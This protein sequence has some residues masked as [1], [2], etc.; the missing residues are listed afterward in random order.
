M[1]DL[2]IS[3]GVMAFISL[4]AIPRPFSAF[5]VGA[6]ILSIGFGVIGFMPF[7]GVNLE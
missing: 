1:Q 5:V 4:L 6:N 7:L 3:V 2:F